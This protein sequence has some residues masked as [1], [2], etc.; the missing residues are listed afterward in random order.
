LAPAEHVLDGAGRLAARLLVAIG[1]G[2]GIGLLVGVGQ[3]SA[4]GLA[5]V[6]V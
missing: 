6:G 2:V 5:Q 1:L 4:G 3:R